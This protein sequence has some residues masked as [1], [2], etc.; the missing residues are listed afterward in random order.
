[1]TANLLTE[2]KG[3]VGVVES[4][5]LGVS[6]GSFPLSHGNCFSVRCVDGSHCKIVNFVLENLEELER[7]GVA[8]PVKVLPIGPRTALVHDARIPDDWYRDRWC[9]VCCP[10]DLL[11]LPQLHRH[12]RQIER[13]ER[14]ENGHVVM[15]IPDKR[16]KV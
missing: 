12:L 4:T 10:R 7:R 15:I 16:P 6:G 5:C 1:M 9:E 11:P 13:G 2:T 8:W 14:V 3:A